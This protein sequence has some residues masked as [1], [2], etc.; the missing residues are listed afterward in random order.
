MILLIKKI[1]NNENNNES[2]NN[3][4][5]IDAIDNHIEKMT[6]CKLYNKTILIDKIKNNLNIKMNYIRKFII[7]NLL[8]EINFDYI[9]FN[10]FKLSLIFV[11]D[12]VSIL[13][14]K[15]QINIY[16]FKN[17][18]LEQYYDSLPIVNTIYV[19][20]FI[21]IIN[22]FIN[23][24]LSVQYNC[25]NIPIHYWKLFEIKCLKINKN[26]YNV[27]SHIIDHNIEEFETFKL[28]ILSYLNDEEI[29]IFFNNINDLNNNNINEILLVLVSIINNIQNNII[30]KIYYIN[31]YFYY[32][33]KYNNNNLNIINNLKEYK[34]FLENN[35]IIFQNNDLKFIENTI[36]NLCQIKDQFNNII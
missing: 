13:Y 31:M 32:I 10:I 30:L 11:N 27:F 2:I 26:Q 19:D 22:K 7:D 16:E 8:C 34:N 25:K 21:N 24:D 29:D 17:I 28:E 20:T 1:L 4:I 36:F 35:I 14:N 5:L 33:I 12:N 18:L 9:F 6:E 23:K 3:E 15:K